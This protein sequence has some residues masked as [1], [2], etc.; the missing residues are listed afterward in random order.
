[1]AVSRGPTSPVG[2]Q[3]EPR[4]ARLL[5]V[6]GV[7]VRAE[8]IPADSFG[9]GALSASS[10]NQFRRRGL[11]VR[12]EREGEKEDTVWAIGDV[13]NARAVVQRP[14]RRHRQGQNGAQRGPRARAPGRSNA[15]EH[16]E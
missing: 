1:M 6:L 16:L 13:A 8:T 15:A 9:L 10:L 5:R 14:R 4:R 7:A 2:L 12:V 3:A 11:L